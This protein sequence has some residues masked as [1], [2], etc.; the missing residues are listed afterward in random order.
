MKKTDKPGVNATIRRGEV[1]I[2]RIAN[3]KEEL[4]CALQRADQVMIRLTET[5]QVDDARLALLCS[6][7]RNAALISREM[8]EVDRFLW[9]VDPARST[10]TNKERKIGDDD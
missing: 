9:A 4:N 1:A 5:S 7:Q 6:A 8:S 3:L 10:G 2:Q